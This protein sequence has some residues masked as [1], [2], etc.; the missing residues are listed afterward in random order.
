MSAIKQP[1]LPLRASLRRERIKSESQF[2]L[3][4][5][6]A[7]LLVQHLKRNRDNKKGN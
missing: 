6:L 1:M 2:E 5:L 4:R 3:A 7:E